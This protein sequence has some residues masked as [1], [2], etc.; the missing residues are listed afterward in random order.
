MVPAPVCAAR[1]CGLIEPCARDW[2]SL[3]QRLAVP[4]VDL[5][6]LFSVPARSRCR[7]IVVRAFVSG[8]D[9]NAK[10]CCAPRRRTRSIT[11]GGGRRKVF[12]NHHATDRFPAW[13]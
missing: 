3:L 1:L 8:W 9:W 10:P 2:T 5:A 4:G 12:T 7:A 11:S 13:W 6:S